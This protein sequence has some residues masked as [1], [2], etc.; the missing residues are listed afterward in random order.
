MS[1][2]ILIVDDDPE[3]RQRL[4]EVL[5]G[6]GY[7]TL[8]ASD[9]AHAVRVAEAL[10]PLVVLVDWRLPDG[11]GLDFIHHLARTQ[12]DT[13]CIAITEAHDL[14]AAL[15]ALKGGADHFLEKP[16]RPQHLLSLVGKEFETALLRNEK[17]RAQ[18]ALRERS[19]QLEEVN[20]RLRLIVESTRKFALCRRVRRLG[21]LALVEFGRNM[22]ARGG[23]LYLRRG[24][25]LVL[26][27]AL[28]PGHAP[29]TLRFPLR[30]DSVFGRAIAQG[31]PLLVEDLAARSGLTGSGWD[32]Y[33]DG[34]CLALPFRETGGPVVGILSLHNKLDPPFTTM[35]RELGR[36]LA[37]F[38]GEA[39]RSLQATEALLESQ[40]R[41][42]RM[43]ANLDEGLLI[44]ERG[45]V[46]FANER[47]CDIFG[48]SPG[49]MTT[50]RVLDVVAPEDRDRVA[51]LMVTI[52]RD[53]AA[54]NELTFQIVRKDGA[55]R[56][57]HNRFALSRAGSNVIGGF[58]IVS[59]ITEQRRRADETRRIEQHLRRSA[60]AEVI[61]HI[62]EQLGHDFNELLTGILA[63]A[64]R[65]G[66]VS[67]PDSPAGRDA[68]MIQ[69]AA[70]RAAGLV[71]RLSTLA[72]PAPE[73]LAPADVH[74][75]LYRVTD[76]LRRMLPRG[77]ALRLRPHAPRSVVLG[78]EA[79]LEQ[80]FLHLG[81]NARDAVGEQG[82]I[83]FETR[84]VGAEATDG[85]A[86]A[87]RPAI[88]VTVR[89]TG[90]G[91]APE[92]RAR[93]FEPG[94]TTREGAAGMGLA[95]VADIVKSHDGAVALESPPG[96]GTAFH[97]RLPLSEATLPPPVS[98]PEAPMRGHGH[99]LLVDDE[100]IVREVA[101]RLLSDLGYEVTAVASGP[102]AIEV[103]R[104]AERPVD[105][106]I[107]DWIMPEMNGR[108]CFRKL[109]EVCPG[110]RAIL[111]TGYLQDGIA[112]E[113]LEEGM[114]GFIAKPYR[115]DQ[116]ARVVHD[117]L[118]KK[119]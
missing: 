73:R 45:R 48:Y 9:C 62:A 46:A 103:C 113:A 8:T 114:V 104:A 4:R 109:R 14:E 115:L 22:D 72:R 65:L 55:R 99:V 119:P 16:I 7:E 44:L 2:S 56:W 49:E 63:S 97:V 85:G 92:V 11:C 86:A 116:L 6:A 67:P 50:L 39:L 23:S 77:V 52:R 25:G 29:N 30:N 28:D 110:L 38:T 81:L 84:L 51:R 54:P 10:R 69:E 33:L 74:A 71:R 106:A 26:I 37:S 78:D 24:E 60:R 101:S 70:E 40:R 5:E 108:E 36:L 87:A 79:E 96:G 68:A 57:V 112:Q 75:V 18:G 61:G 59:D 89:D 41:F 19:R 98:P 53:P 32:G 83:A 117:A 66:H 27:H 3:T 58:V 93:L 20:Y 94:V 42:R 35:D 80:V 95:T 47:A 31:R 76:L 64:S 100:R 91:V 90:A 13:A 102:E 12:P 43:A 118:A 17:L 105:L 21:E 1:D 107:L 111:S 82:E 34:S 88:E 15:E